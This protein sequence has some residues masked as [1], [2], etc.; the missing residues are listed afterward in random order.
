MTDPDYWDEVTERYDLESAK[1]LLE[2][3]K[4]NRATSCSDEISAV[5]AKYG[6]ELRATP[7]EVTLVPKEAA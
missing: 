1:R 5:L 6:F 4:A 3:D 2:Q 7:A